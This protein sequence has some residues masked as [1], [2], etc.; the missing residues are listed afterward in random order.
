MNDQNKLKN[1]DTKPE[2]SEKKSKAKGSGGKIAVAVAAALFS[3]VVIGLATGVLFAPKK[4]Q[5]T[6][7]EIA[8][9]SKELIERSKKSV[10]GTI[11]KTVEFTKESKGKRQNYKPNQNH[12]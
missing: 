3:G 10:S 8:D 4:G 7:K 1:Q 5:K 2:V 11:D 6:R 9:K 12:N